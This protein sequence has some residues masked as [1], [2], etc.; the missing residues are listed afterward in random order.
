MQSVIGVPKG[1]DLTPEMEADVKAIL[2][3]TLPLSERFDGFIFDTYNSGLNRDFRESI[4]E[5]SPYPLNK[6]ETPV[7]VTNALDDP[8]AVPENVRGLA[9]KL[10]N[11]RLFVVPDGGHTLLGHSQQIRAEIAQF[12]NSNVTVSKN[13]Q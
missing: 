4:S 8:Y 11:A 13:G 10:P 12:L 9:E 5:T 1:F 2:A 6:I 7:L 3:S